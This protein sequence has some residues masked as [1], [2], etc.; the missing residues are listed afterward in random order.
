MTTSTDLQSLLRRI[1]KAT[2][3]LEELATKRADSAPCGDST[4]PCVDLATP[5]TGAENKVVLEYE[6]AVQP[7]IAKFVSY[8]DK[9]GGVVVEQARLVEAL[10]QAQ[11]SFI[12]IATL[13][14]KPT[15]DQLPALLG[16]QQN[17]IRQ[18]IALRDANRPSENFDNLSTI[19]EG[20]AAF[21][22]VA[23]EPTPV[24]YIN[25]MKDSAQFYANRVLKKWREKDE[26][27]VEW[28]KAFLG[29]LRELSAY[30]KLFHTTGLVW[31]PKGEDV[32]KAA[33]AINGDDNDAV[34]AS[35]AP[36]HGA[37][38]PPPP[39]PPPPP[40]YTDSSET[41]ADR[42][43]G[44]TTRGALFADLNKGGDIT[45]GLRKVEK[46]QMTH[47]NPALRANSGAVKSV[48]HSASAT[49]QQAP[50]K[51]QR[52]PRMELQGSKWVV[53][54]YRTEHLT[55]EA[56]ETKQTV[57]MFNCTGTTLEIIGKL[58]GIAIDNCQKCGVVFDSLVAQCEIV[59]CKSV[60]V[61]V[62][63]TVPAIQ[64]DRT[65]GAQLFLSETARDNTQIT[66]AKASEVNVAYPFETLNPEDDNSV[67]QPI[68]EQLQTVIKNGKL[69][70]TVLEHSS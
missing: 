2:T 36:A 52:P 10:Y 55:I 63:E 8:S 56:T 15:M 66:T 60:Q 70:T 42:T 29:T 9:I 23:V 58:N 12:R 20:I 33:R 68:P 1:E 6:A 43:A 37:S 50:V 51:Q 14:K 41:S 53:E 28:V 31:N 49:Q 64:I 67:E 32:E 16:P 59:N 47:K 3:R 48:A 21:G 18:I 45:S 11:H 54:N 40:V 4:A 25:D 24:P 61:Q 7:Q 39:P 19:A 17:A 62:R 26:N 5:N 65:D 46:A 34:S 22:W 69:V 57:Y 27:Q 38:A 35:E 13:T 44:A 30:V